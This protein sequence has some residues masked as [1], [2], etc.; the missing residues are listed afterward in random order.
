MG[1]GWISENSSQETLDYLD[2]C[3][4]RTSPAPRPETAPSFTP[5]AHST[6]RPWRCHGSSDGST[7]LRVCCVAWC[8]CWSKY[9]RR[10]SCL[11]IPCSSGAK[12]QD[13][14]NRK[15]GSWGGSLL[16][17]KQPPAPCVHVTS[18]WGLRGF[19]SSYR[20]TDPLRSGRLPDHPESLP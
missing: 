2:A 5:T 19:S 17:C 1:F 7:G 11:F 3:D 14:G 15:L 18:V 12:I 20:D 8:G 13:Q 4:T 10:P 9:G 6:R 16:P